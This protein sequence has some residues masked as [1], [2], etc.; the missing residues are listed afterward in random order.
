[1][2]ESDKILITGSSGM[3][4]SALARYLNK[5]NYNNILIPSR[6]EL[7][8]LNEIEVK[9]YLTN[10]TP[11][12]IFAAAAKVGG[13][14]TNMRNSVVFLSENLTMQNNL[15]TQAHLCGVNNLLF[16][17]SSC[18]YPKYSKQ[19]INEN[20]LLNGYLEETNEAYALAKICGLKL[21]DYYKKQFSRNYFSIMPT[22]LYGINDNY[23]EKNSH[24]IPAIIKKIHNAK[25]N[26]QKEVSLFGTGK[27][28]REF[29][30]VDDLA[31]ASILAMKKNFKHSII[32]VGSGK[33]INILDL[34]QLIAK[35]IGHNLNFI[36]NINLPDGTPRKFLDS[37]RIR[38]F[39]W[40]PNIS[41]DDGLLM[42]YNS[43]LESI[44]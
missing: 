40:K 39:G 37:S 8:L 2:I 26:N 5:N 31:E 7:N 10:K 11:N 6:D 27:A 15:I 21:C 19:P 20:E 13:I 35:I 9:E 42:A 36:F 43:Y 22:N 23:D 3:V 16:Y 24:V 38:S 4:G 18:I 14:E 29:L 32:N 33:E 30:Y 12:F 1:M 17:G 34:A 28:L 44:K 25:I 41:L